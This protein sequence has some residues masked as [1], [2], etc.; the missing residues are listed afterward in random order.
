MYGRNR[1]AVATLFSLFA[2]PIHAED[3]AAKEVATTDGNIRCISRQ[4]WLVTV[5]TGPCTEF[6]PPSRLSLGSD[7]KA[8]GKDRSIGAIIASQASK[9]LKAPGVDIKKGEWTC[10]LG[11]TRRDLD[12]GGDHTA[13]WLYIPKC[14]PIG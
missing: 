2:F 14:K 1:L 11:E 13:I 3:F 4:D 6:A 8:N 5:V 9:D 12:T 7:F 10:I